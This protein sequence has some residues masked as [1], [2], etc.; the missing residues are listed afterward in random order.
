MDDNQLSCCSPYGDQDQYNTAFNM[1]H[2]CVLDFLF[3]AS[4]N[5]LSLQYVLEVSTGESKQCISGFTAI[6]V[7][8]GPLWYATVPMIPCYTNATLQILS[9][10]VASHNCRILGD[11]FMG[12]YHTVFDYGKLQIG[13]A[14]AARG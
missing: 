10:N 1:L 3:L 11:I 12:V 8:Q 6:D 7:T 2:Y 4:Q 13:F 9:S 5:S 14:E